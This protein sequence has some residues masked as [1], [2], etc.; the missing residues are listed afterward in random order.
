[1]RKN[2]RWFV[3]PSLTT[4]RQYEALRAFY[5]EELSAEEAAKRF[6]YKAPSFH[7]LLS[8]NRPFRAEAFFRDRKGGRRKL[9]ADDPV[10]EKI[11]TLRKK[12]YSV[13]DIQRALRMDKTPRSHVAILSVLKEE[14]FARLPRRPDEERPSLDVPKPIQAPKASILARRWEPGTVHKTNA[15]G[16]FL[17]IPFLI[18][19]KLPQLVRGV[20]FPG[21]WM[22]PP[23]QYILSHLALKLQGNERYSHVMDMCLDEGLGLFAGLNFIPKK[24]ALTDYSYRFKRETNRSFMQ[25]FFRNFSKT[26]L[27][28]GETFNLDFHTIPYY[29]EEE[30]TLEHNYVPRRGHGERSVL[31]FL[32]QDGSSRVLCYSNADVRR[33]DRSSEIIQFVHYW[34]SVRKRNPPCLVFDSQLTN[35]QTM[36]ELSRLDILFITLRRRGQGIV[37]DLL[38]LPRNAWR[39]VHLD[40]PQRKYQNP[41]VVESDIRVSGYP[42]NLRQLAVRDLGRDEPTLI[43]TNDYKSEPREIIVRYAQRMIIENAL[44]E[45]IAFFH[46]DSL[47]SAVVLNADFSITFTLIA[48]ALY[49]LLAHKLRGFEKTQAKRLFR[50]VLNIKATAVIGQKDVTIHYERRR[51]NPMLLDANFDAL[52]VQV[53]WWD[54]RLLKFAFK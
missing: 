27:L 41:S 32:A 43:I 42:Y 31:T 18:D 6:G 47:S 40:L 7:V 50:S 19:L 29:G 9:A 23:L 16:I 14:G 12:N 34:R 21:S 51:H 36:A 35:Y 24:S 39:R 5:V 22:I 33:Q 38:K 4:H 20:G 11:I 3:N 53:P 8:R 30:E 44:A 15:G 28:P 10:R 17:F 45:N 37:A 54:N 49:K 13:Y 48:N 52:T 25:G 2:G 26:E 46:L 1:M